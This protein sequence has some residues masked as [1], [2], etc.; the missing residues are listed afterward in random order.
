[1]LIGLLFVVMLVVSVGLLFRDGLWSNLISL[2]NVV[3]AALLA[4]NFFEPV[5]G[6]LT[7]LYAP[8]IYFWDFVAVWLCFLVFFLLMRIPTELISRVQV[9]FPSMVNAAGSALVAFCIGWV[10]VCFTAMTL[11]MAPLARDGFRGGLAPEEPMFFGMHPDRM[12]L[13]YV[14]RVSHD[15]RL[16]TGRNRVFDPQAE[17]LIK[18]ATRREHFSKQ[19]QLFLPK[20]QQPASGS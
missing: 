5:A 6:W 14:H 7:V 20:A 11:H 12:W 15:D 13:A 17:F 19:E 10:M 4:T 2:F 3:M 8:A 1:M 18:Y 16:G 9:R